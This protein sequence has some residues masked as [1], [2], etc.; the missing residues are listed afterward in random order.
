MRVTFSDER[1][2]SSVI[3]CFEVDGYRMRTV[4]SRSIPSTRLVCSIITLFILNIVV[5]RNLTWSRWI[6]PEDATL[7]EFLCI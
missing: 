2:M 7:P 1:M 5:Q 4:D 6:T 3:A